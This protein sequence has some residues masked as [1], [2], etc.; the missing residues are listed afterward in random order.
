MSLIILSS[1]YVSNEMRCEFGEVPPCML[2][3]GGKLLLEH[4]LEFLGE[5]DNFLSLPSDYVLNNHELKVISEL[6]LNIIKFHYILKI[7][8]FISLIFLKFY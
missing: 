4:Q 8:F 7:I 1:S 5:R 2:P 3:L 6:K